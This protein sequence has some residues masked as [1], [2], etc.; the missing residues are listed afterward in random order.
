MK[1]TIVWIHGWGMSPDAW[2]E[3]PRLLADFHHSYFSYAGCE[4]L[5]QMRNRLILKLQDEGPCFVS[6][7]SMGAMLVLELVLADW[8]R[9]G[10]KAADG[11]GAAN[12]GDGLAIEAMLLIGATLRFVGPDRTRAW[13][14]RIVKRMR[15]QAVLELEATLR[16]FA[17][18]MFSEKERER[19]F[20]GER[21]WFTDMT[22]AGLDAGLAYLLEADLFERWLRFREYG[23]PPILW[24]H[25]ED[26]PICPI[27]ALGSVPDEHKIVMPGAGHAPFITEPQTIAEHVRRIFR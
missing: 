25:G 1:P 15:S 3:V 11:A 2:G 7:W 10:M 8:E 5:E 14:E 18:S 19:G 26:D 6:A 23:S 13:P 17:S 22:P 20:P 16:A 4:T 21:A 24:L 12:S 27:G 9:R